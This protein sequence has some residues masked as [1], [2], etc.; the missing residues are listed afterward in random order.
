MIG[1]LRSISRGSECVLACIRTFEGITNEEN[2]C[3][4]DTDQE[5]KFGCYHRGGSVRIRAS[6]CARITGRSVCAG[7]GS[8]IP[9]FVLSEI[10]FWESL[11]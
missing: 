11:Q 5:S 6:A 4:A 9:A 2:L 7:R 10:D 3:R 1:W 8:E